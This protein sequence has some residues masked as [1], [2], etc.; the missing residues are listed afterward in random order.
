ME[1]LSTRTRPLAKRDTGRSAIYDDP[2][3]RA[4]HPGGAPLPPHGNH[5]QD[6]T[7]SWVC[8][9]PVCDFEGQ[10]Q[11]SSQRLSFRGTG[12]HDHNFGQVPLGDVAAWY[13]ARAEL[14]CSDGA[15]R[16]AILYYLAS[17]SDPRPA[18]TEVTVLVFDRE[19]N[20]AAC[21]DN[22]VGSE[23]SPVTNAYGL[24]HSTI[25]TA[26]SSPGITLKAAFSAL[27][28]TFSEGPFYRRL[29]AEIT[30][31]YGS[32]WTGV[33]TGIGEVFVPSRLCGPIA[34]RAMW[35]RIRR[36]GGKRS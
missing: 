26:E 18:V 28:G 29:P 15:V 22:A 1:R 13:W 7:H 36:R 6:D 11:V 14:R 33:G 12:Y 27:N 30:A 34:S 10:I 35:S 32:K 2:D 25:V 8:V 17:N 24:T 4:A 9:A 21:S 23:Y 16:T 5:T 3:R 20:G 31:S 19:G